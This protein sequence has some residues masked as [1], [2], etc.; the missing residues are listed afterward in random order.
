M[1]MWLGVPGWAVS[2]S[3]MALCVVGHHTFLVLCLGK[4]FFSSTNFPFESINRTMSASVSS[5]LEG[6]EGGLVGVG[7]G[8]WLVCAG[9]AVSGR[10]F[11]GLGRRGAA[12]RAGEA[13]LIDLGSSAV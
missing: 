12:G 13:W 9:A 3:Y 11:C 2:S 4:R 1:I 6:A 5:G 10:L 8:V 7:A